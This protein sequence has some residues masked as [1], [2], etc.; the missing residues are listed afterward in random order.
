[1][2]SERVQSR[3]R[4]SNIARTR[5]HERVLRVVD[6]LGGRVLGRPRRSP[7][8]NSVEARNSR[9]DLALRQPSKRAVRRERDG[10]LHQGREQS[11]ETQEG[12]LDRRHG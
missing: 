2:V 9:L 4:A 7:R 6:E 11:E 3:A 12:G 8:D 1:M 5:S 10:E